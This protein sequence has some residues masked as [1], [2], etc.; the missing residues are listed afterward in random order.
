MNGCSASPVFSNDIDKFVFIFIGN[1]IC[2]QFQITVRMKLMF[3]FYYGK[4][5]LPGWTNW[6][7]SIKEYLDD[8]RSLYLLIG[9]ISSLVILTLLLELMSYFS[10]HVPYATAE[11]EIPVELGMVKD[12]KQITLLQQHF[13]PPEVNITFSTNLLDDISKSVIVSDDIA[14]DTLE[15]LKPDTLNKKV[16]DIKEEADV[17]D[18][19][20]LTI[21]EEKPTFPGGTE[22]LLKFLATNVK[23]PPIA[24]EAGI[25][26][27]VLIS[28]LIEK[29]GSISNIKVLHSIGGGCNE[30]AIRVVSLMPKWTPAKQKGKPILTQFQIPLFFVLRAN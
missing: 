4:W 8:K 23:Y 25:T 3:H 13:T 11:I 27:T 16:S 18:S 19:I 5:R 20:P 1:Y 17:K 21:V 12:L 26:G 28:F 10:G 15:K 24:K 6:K 7:N 22:A 29:D 2:K 30:E 9:L 14:L